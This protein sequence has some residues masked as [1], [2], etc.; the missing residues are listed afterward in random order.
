MS[1]NPKVYDIYHPLRR[2][3]QC[4]YACRSDKNSDKPSWSFVGSRFK[5][6][7]D[8][9][10]VTLDILQC[11]A[12]DSGV[13]MCKA[14]NLAGEAVSSCST[15]VLGNYKE[16]LCFMASVIHQYMYFLLC[17]QHIIISHGVHI[18]LLQP[19]TAS[20]A[21]SFTQA[22]KPSSSARLNGTACPRHQPLLRLWNHPCSQNTW[23]AKS[24]CR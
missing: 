9:G 21:T 1:A 7:S 20:W 24:A 22:G 3:P 11:V 5:T 19:R 4:N 13:Y 23:R 8:F 6:T 10:Y 15:R 17:H 2:A 14:I 12:E 18:L 16:K